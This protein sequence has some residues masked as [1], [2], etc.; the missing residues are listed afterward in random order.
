MVSSFQGSDSRAM[1]ISGGWNRVNCQ[2]YCRTVNVNKEVMLMNLTESSRSLSLLL[3]K[4][5]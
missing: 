5:D 1:F 4:L 3:V 2:Y